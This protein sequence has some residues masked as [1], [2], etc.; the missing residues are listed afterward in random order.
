M[1]KII[2]KKICILLGWGFVILGAIGAVLPVL[3]TTP[4]LILALA[5]FS[6]SSP[7]FHQMLLEN[8]W[9]GKG[10]RQWEE[11]KTLTRKTKNT[12]YIS[13][14]LTFTLSIAILR[15]RLELQ[16]LLLGVGVILLCFLW[17]VPVAVNKP[18]INQ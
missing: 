3:P 8:K 2:Q 5:L 17:R 13:I 18:A 16:I 11:Q 4:F 10:L 12:A 6:R 14:V 1:N 7:R 15:D 9:F